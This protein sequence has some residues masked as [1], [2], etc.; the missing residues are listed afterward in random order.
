MR[1]AAASIA[2]RTAPALVLLDRLRDA[3]QHTEKECARTNG[4]VG[5]DHVGRGKAGRPLE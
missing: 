5:Y 2:P 4:R 1:F 3:A